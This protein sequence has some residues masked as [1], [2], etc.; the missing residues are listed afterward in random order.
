[1]VLSESEDNPPSRRHE[2]LAILKDGKKA[3]VEQKQEKISWESLGKRQ[4]LDCKAIPGCLCS[5]CN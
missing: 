1:M 5:N 4:A 3:K 2:P